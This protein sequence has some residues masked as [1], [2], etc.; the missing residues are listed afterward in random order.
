METLETAIKIFSNPAFG[1]IRTIT[2]TDGSI[3]F[4]SDDIALILWYTK[5]K[6]MT[7]HLDDNEI[8]VHLVN[9]KYS[10]VINENGLCSAIAC[11]KNPKAREIKQWIYTNILKQK[12][13]APME[14]INM[15]SVSLVH[16]N[17]NG[18]D[19]TTS[20][21][22][23]EVFGKRHAD[24]L[25]D[26]ENMSCSQEFRE[27]NFALSSYITSQ[28]KE[29]PMYEITKDG[30]SFLVMGYTGNKAGEFKEK[31]ISEFN[32]RE[33]LLKND[34]Y[35]IARSQEILGNRVKALEQQILQKDRQIEVKDQIIKQAEPK[36]LFA[37]AVETSN[38]SVL[39]SELAKIISQNGYVIG[40]NRLFTW[41]RDNGYLLSKGEY[42]NQPSQR[43]IELGLFELKKQTIGKPN[44]TVLAATTTVVTGKGQIY[45]VNKFLKA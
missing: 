10:V 5:V 43:A 6:T 35:I 23:A 42:Y 20:L 24:V 34:D 18:V 29:L 17:K 33:Y 39:V 25:R 40:Q 27:R 36:V 15:P 1:E 41:L 3:L 12:N 19:I 8:S 16:S 45:F 11:S 21:I 14:T 44:G 9:G 2:D 28:S 32:K 7:R 26:I 30:F 37:N 4:V 31:F 22:V 38:K 13:N